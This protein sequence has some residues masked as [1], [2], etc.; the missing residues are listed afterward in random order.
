MLTRDD[1]NLLLAAV[2][3]LEHQPRLQYALD[4]ATV[5][6][7]SPSRELVEAG[8]R[9][10]EAKYVQAEPSRRADEERCTL[11]KAKLLKL[12]QQGPSPAEVCRAWRGQTTDGV[13][14]S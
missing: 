9:D 5:A 7:L 3:A 1:I 14:P 8:V 13:S 4:L 11:L 12:R 6:V 2:A 10:L